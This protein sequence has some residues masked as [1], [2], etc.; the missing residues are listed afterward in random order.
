MAKIVTVSNLA[1]I[2]QN[3]KKQ[4]KKIV[5]SGG[6]FDVLHPG[7]VIFLEKAKKAGD[8][9]VV[10]LE[11][12]KKVRELKG[13]GRPIHSQE[14]R[15]KVLSALSA[16]DY[17][18]MLPYMN[19]DKEYDQLIMKIKPDVIA[20]TARDANNAHHLRSAKLSGA[21]LK[22]VTKMIGNYSTSK[23]LK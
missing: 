11:S 18:V 16:V 15:A 8:I 1:K 22:L 17:I 23:L 3:P 5:L 10:F 4:N 7:H 19:R 9:L 21:K 12:D 2:I 14:E 6:C 20:A 13:I